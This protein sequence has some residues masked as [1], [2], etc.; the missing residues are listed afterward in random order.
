MIKGRTKIISKHALKIPLSFG[1]NRL[2]KQ[3]EREGR[4]LLEIHSI[5]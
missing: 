1:K 2:G 5:N 4:N 3:R